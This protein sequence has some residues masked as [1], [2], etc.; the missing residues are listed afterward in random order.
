LIA[1]AIAAADADY[2]YH[3]ATPSFAAISL[4]THIL[5]RHAAISLRYGM[6][7]AAP[8]PAAAFSLL[9]LLFSPL[10]DA[11]AAHYADAIF[12]SPIIFADRHVDI[13][14]RCHD[15]AARV[16]AAMLVTRGFSLATLLIFAAAMLMPATAA[17]D[18]CRYDFRR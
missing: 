7:L 14:I 1:A 3:C 17:A 10:H 2:A 6:M 5:L 11:A 12:S 8:P 13:T 16:S 18:V 4:P 15:A 9:L